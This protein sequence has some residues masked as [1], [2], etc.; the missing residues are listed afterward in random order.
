MNHGVM[1]AAEQAQGSGGR[2]PQ[3]RPTRPGTMKKV[4]TRDGRV[5][6]GMPVLLGSAMLWPL[7][8]VAADEDMGSVV[9]PASLETR[10]AE[11]SAAITADSTLDAATRDA[12]LARLRDAQR[13]LE[14]GAADRREA[15]RL[16]EQRHAAPAV[17]AGLASSKPESPT[18]AEPVEWRGLS[19]AQFEIAASE[20]E[21][22]ARAASEQ[23]AEA[24]QLLA[25]LRG[26]RPLIGAQL[27][28]ARQAVTDARDEVARI[29]S[30]GQ[31]VAGRGVRRSGPGAPTVARSASRIAGGTE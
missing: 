30:A 3:G 8:I 4:R 28:K 13:L 15:E 21:N 20:A 24:R 22:R 25:D 31:K 2:R 12:S 6:R 1:P 17:L 19:L 18:G 23:A 5:R 10:L 9:P 29:H 26:N 14:A 16:A 11:E 27:A 7:L